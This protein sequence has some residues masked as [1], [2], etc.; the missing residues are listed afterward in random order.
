MS[1]HSTNKHAGTSRKDSR[2]G[3]YYVGAKTGKLPIRAFLD[4]IRYYGIMA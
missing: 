3:F 2:T 1:A 4:R